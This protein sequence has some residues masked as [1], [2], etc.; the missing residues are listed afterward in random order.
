MGSIFRAL[1]VDYDGTLT[2][3]GRRPRGA[4]LAALARARAAGCRVLLVTGRILSELRADFPD[5]DEHVDAIVAENGCVLASGGATRLITPP[6]D[7]ALARAL[8]DAGV[9]VRRGDALLACDAVLA[10]T[11]LGQIRR[12]GLDCQLVH[13]R[14]ALM[15]LPAGVTKGTGLF[16]AL[17][18]LGVS[19]H[20][21]IGVGDAENDHALLDVCEVAVA[22]ANA[23][24]SLRRHADVVTEGEDGDGVVELLDGPVLDGREA[25]HS[26]RW[27]VLLGTATDGEPVML[28]ASQLDLLVCG[29]TGVGKSYAAGLLAERLVGLGYSVLVVDPEGDHGELARLRGAVTVDAAEGLPTPSRLAALFR[30]RFT[31][32]VLDLSCLPPVDR[33]AY[34]DG[35]AVQVAA[36]RRDLG[37]PHWVVLDEAHASAPERFATGALGPTSRFKGQVLVTY[38]PFDLAAEVLD[39][40]DG[41]L[42][43]GGDEPLPDQ[44][45]EIASRVSGLERD[46]VRRMVGGLRPREG[47]LALRPALGRTTTLRLSARSTPQ[48]RHAHKYGAVQVSPEK[49]FYFRDV[50]DRVV[51]VAGSMAELCL[52]LARVDD[53]VLVHHAAGHDLSRWISSVFQDGALATAVAETEHQLSRHRIPVS[54]ERARVLAAVVRRYP[55]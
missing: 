17:G 43:L 26:R 35:L 25:V 3:D 24:P 52:A 48:V 49:R 53:G 39:G 5:V 23:V 20:S 7:A 38:R 2:R 22:V 18:D 33:R 29:D 1:A 8:L 37:L 32:V 47:L 50:D 30:Q 14:S 54:E 10:V 27:D 9:P 45:V 13:N 4:V 31:S 34:L 40:L 36:L 6:V 15:V 51:D 46:R 11:V 41:M 21:T 19:R 44:V 28:P 55:R 42:A 12:L 16:E